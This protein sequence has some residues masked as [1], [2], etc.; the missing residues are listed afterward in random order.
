MDKSTSYADYHSEMHSSNTAHFD[1]IKNH[2]FFTRFQNIVN[3]RLSRCGRSYSFYTYGMAPGRVYS[4][5][6][7]L[8]SL[9]LFVS[10]ENRRKLG[11]TGSPGNWTGNQV[12]STFY[13]LVM[14]VTSNWDKRSKTNKQKNKAKTKAKKKGK[15]IFKIIGL[16]VF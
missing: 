13:L 9:L 3:I 4:T 5:Y 6:N 11:I 10:T 2:V 14:I 12:P 1:L 7:F 8:L 16:S 15:Y